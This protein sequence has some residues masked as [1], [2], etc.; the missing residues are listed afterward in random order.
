MAAEMSA[1]KTKRRTRG[2][3]TSN[4]S[5]SS[6]P[7][8]PSFDAEFFHQHAVKEELQEFDEYPFVA[9]PTPQN[10]IE[11]STS[12]FST[13]A[14][15]YYSRSPSPSEVGL[16]P[17]IIATSS[18][19]TQHPAAMLCGLQCQSEEEKWRVLGPTIPERSRQLQREIFLSQL[20]FLTLI[21]AVSSHLLH[22]LRLIISSL[23]TGSPLPRKMTPKTAPMIFL[24]IKWL[25]STRANLIL[26]PS[27]TATITTDSSPNHH[28]TTFHP[29]PVVRRPTIRIR[30]L[31]R[32]LLCSPALAR[33]LKGATDRALRPKTS[34]AL[35]RNSS[36]PPFEGGDRPVIDDGDGV[37]I[38]LDFGS[39][40]VSDITDNWTARERELKR[41]WI[42]SEAEKGGLYFYR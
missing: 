35:N 7:P 3:I 17:H 26:T 13:P 41:P 29:S 32:L 9:L 39:G 12:S 11:S 6:C 37:T 5:T 34:Y 15:T 22:L 1:F 2:S 16:G 24:L 19:M 40:V 14:S 4:S 33:P 23:R 42:F 38:R 36:R 25:I 31:Q 21:S 8:S 10:S 30:L 20:L 18:D 28:P 27:T